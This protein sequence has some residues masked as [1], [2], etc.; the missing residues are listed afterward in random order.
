L[1]RIVQGRLRAAWP[2]TNATVVHLRAGDVIEEDG[3]GVVELLTSEAWGGYVKPLVGGTLGAAR[4]PFTFKVRW[5]TC[6]WFVFH[7]C[8]SFRAGVL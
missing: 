2:Q 3:R 1:L 5:N 7:R 4:L 6:V 8:L